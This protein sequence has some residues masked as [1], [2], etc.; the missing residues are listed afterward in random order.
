MRSPWLQLL[1]LFA[2]LLLVLV[3][4]C[5]LDL[6]LWYQH[7]L[8]PIQVVNPLLLKVRQ[9]KLLL[10]SRGV[11][12][13]EYFEKNELVQVLQDSAEVM[14]GEVEQVSAITVPLKERLTRPPTAISH[15]TGGAH[16]YEQVE[17]T[18]DS[19]W[20]VQVVTSNEP[21]LDDY[22]WRL[23]CHQLEP[24]GIR[25]GIFDCRQDYKLCET[26][27]WVEPLLL[28]AMP[29]G[30]KA[31]DKVILQPFT[32][33]KPQVI[34][35]W[36]HQQLSLWVKRIQSIDEV[37]KDW[38]DM[39][40]NVTI[41][42]SGSKENVLSTPDGTGS[43]SVSVLLLTQLLQPPLFLA[44]LSIKF[45]GR[46]NFGM[47]TVK[48][49]DTETVRKRLRLNDRKLPVYIVITPE[50]KVVYGSRKLEYFNMWSMNVFLR[51]I[52]PEMND[53]FLFSLL[54][55]NMLV[56]LTVCLTS[57]HL[58][59]R[60]AVYSLWALVKYNLWLFS[61]WLVFIAMARFEVFGLVIDRLLLILRVVGLSDSGSFVRTELAVLTQNP[62]V[63]L[64]SFISFVLSVSVL[65]RFFAPSWLISAPNDLPNQRPWWEVLP[66]DSYW[67]NYLFRP[68]ASLSRPMPTSQTELEDGIEMLIERLAVPN[69]WLQSVIPVDYIK[70][71][72][73]WRYHGW[74]VVE[75]QP[76]S[77]V[78]IRDKLL[79]TS[80]PRF[81]EHMMDAEDP[82]NLI[83]C[84]C[85]CSGEDTG[86]HSPRI[87]CSQHLT[88]THNSTGSSDSLLHP[89]NGCLCSQEQVHPHSRGGSTYTQ[90]H[91]NFHSNGSSKP[92]FKIPNAGAS[93]QSTQCFCPLFPGWTK[94]SIGNSKAPG[95]CQNCRD[96]CH[97][98]RA[99]RTSG[100]T[101]SASAQQSRNSVWNNCRNCH[102]LETDIEESDISDSEST[103]GWTLPEGMLATTDCAVC[104][105]C[106]NY[107]SVLCGLPCGHNYHQRC[108]LAWL[109]R[110]N[111]HC[112]V[113][114]WPAY[115]T[116]AQRIHLHQE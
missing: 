104:L 79:H 100:S 109:Q 29:K 42:T 107:G 51:G 111:H 70:D 1:L 20:L 31:K 102:W 87:S 66:M 103:I 80:T 45:T 91:P 16:F 108:I 22:N 24:F 64:I 76:I 50:K 23:V 44:A 46:V 19:V 81:L 13:T 4:S 86:D 78:C 101:C 89:T 77:S 99:G 14:M 105:E 113:C 27:G 7:G 72:P 41:N 116:K 56:G 37:E 61:A 17:D 106:Y 2:Y 110:D 34:V 62:I 73:V 33:S 25:I 94:K 38:L 3:A 83:P 71:L 47:L 93:E 115:R 65:I 12:Y 69:F 54:L 48:K 10:D 63:F 88:H 6:I 36:V 18:R 95:K 28:L 60:W 11:S 57:T 97:K 82:P 68:M 49:E 21:L 85:V 15:F 74:N 26:K 112:P 5:L 9:I 55:V 8:S 67:V 114:R 40:Q 52:Q 84:C 30:R 39:S 96:S 92:P 32:S 90:E 98:I 59:F 75:E 43:T 58:W 35:D 53:V